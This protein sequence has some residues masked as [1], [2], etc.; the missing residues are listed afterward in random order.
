[1]SQNP[2]NHAYKASDLQQ[3]FDG[4]TFGIREITGIGSRQEGLTFGK[5]ET[6]ANGSV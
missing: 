5:K 3:S 1:M 2:S 4:Y 6:T